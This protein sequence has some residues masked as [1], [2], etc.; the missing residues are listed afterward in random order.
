MGMGMPTFAKRVSKSARP[1]NSSAMTRVK[2]TQKSVTV[3][4][5]TVTNKPRMDCK[6][7]K[8]GPHATG[9]MPTYVKRVNAPASMAHSLAMITKTKTPIYAMASITIVIPT[10]PMVPMIRDSG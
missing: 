7:H 5:T 6:T 2:K 3:R 10:H 4:I 8:Q 1:V 9:K